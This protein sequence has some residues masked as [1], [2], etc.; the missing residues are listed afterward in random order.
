MPP[1][2]Y[3]LLGAGDVNINVLRDFTW[4]KEVSRLVR[5]TLTSKL[6]SKL[7]PLLSFFSLLVL[8][9]RPKLELNH[10]LEDEDVISA[11]AGSSIIYSVQRK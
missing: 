10:P 4:T 6:V 8:L 2:K 3:K 9:L 11:F 7:V 5:S 1:Y